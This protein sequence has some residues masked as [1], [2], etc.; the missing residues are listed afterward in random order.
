MRCVSAHTAVSPRDA[1]AFDGHDETFYG[2]LEEIYRDMAPEPTAASAAGDDRCEAA[3]PA[4]SDPL[5]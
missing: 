3:A 2:E 4:R 5:T 1:R